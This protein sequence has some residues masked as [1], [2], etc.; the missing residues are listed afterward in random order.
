MLKIDNSVGNTV[1]LLYYIHIC[2]F[3]KYAALSTFGIPPVNFS[4]VQLFLF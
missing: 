3:I 2:I 4:V 1:L